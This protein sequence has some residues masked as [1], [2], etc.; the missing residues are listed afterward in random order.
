MG[1]KT[2][3]RLISSVLSL[4][5][6]C[7]QFVTMPVLAEENDVR[8]TTEAQLVLNSYEL[9]D[10]EKAILGNEGIVS[11][12]VKYEAPTGP[13]DYV[14]LD[15]NEVLS[16]GNYTDSQGNV[17]KP[18]L[19]ELVEGGNRTP[20]AL[21]DGKV[22]IDTDS[23]SYSVEVKY[24][25]YVSVPTETQAKLL[26]ATYI[27]ANASKA[28]ETLSVDAPAE[29]TRFDVAAQ[30]K[31][32]T[33]WL[34]TM[35]DG[36]EIQPAG[37]PSPMTVYI[38]DTDTIAAIEAMHAQ[39][40]RTGSYVNGNYDLNVLAQGYS[41]SDKI[42]YLLAS[43]ASV[44]TEA[45]ETRDQ[46]LSIY[47]NQQMNSWFTFAGDGIEKD[48]IGMILNTAFDNA[49]VLMSVVG[50]SDADASAGN[51]AEYA[52]VV[53][54]IDVVLGSGLVADGA[55]TAELTALI[56]AAVEAGKVT[57]RTNTAVQETL[58]VDSA[59]VV[60]SLNNNDVT[61][62]V[63]AEVY[64][65]SEKTT[66]TTNDVV[67]RLPTGTTYADVESAVK[68]DVENPFVSVND[69]AYQL[70]S[71]NYDRV[72]ENSIGNTLEEDSY[73]TIKYTPKSVQVTTA[74]DGINAEY[75]YGYGLMLPS[76]FEQNKAYTYT[77]VTANETKTLSEGSVYRITEA[78]TITRTEDK[79]SK[80]YRIL[81][82]LADD[83]NYSFTEAE[84]NVL[85]N[86]AVKS[87]VVSYK[88]PEA[89]DA[90][91]LLELKASDGTLTALP[92]ASG[93]AGLEWVPVG[94]YLNGVGNRIDFTGTATDIPEGTKSVKVDY[95]L[96][97]VGFDVESLLP[98][99]SKLINDSIAQK[100][101]LDSLVVE[102]GK[103]E[104]QKI[105]GATIFTALGALET[106][107]YSTYELGEDTPWENV[108]QK[109][110]EVIEIIGN[111][112]SDALE[113]KDGTRKLTVEGY[114]LNYKQNGL[115][116][117]YQKD[118]YGKSGYDYFMEQLDLLSVSL[119]A[120]ISS[121]KVSAFLSQPQYADYATKLTMVSESLGA[122]Q[123]AL[124]PPS[125]DVDMES[126][127]LASLFAL[128]EN[129]GETSVQT[130]NGITVRT[131]LLAAD[132]GV[133]T[134]KVTVTVN[135]LNLNDGEVKETVSESKKYVVGG[136]FTSEEVNEIA[137]LQATAE[138]QLA[139]NLDYYK[140]SITGKFP[141]T[142]DAVADTEIV[143]TYEPLI[144]SVNVNG[145]HV[146]N[147]S[148][149]DL[150]IPLPNHASAGW[151]YIYSID[152]TELVVTD[153]VYT[154]NLETFKSYATTGVLDITRTEQNVGETNLKEM[155]EIL[156]DGLGN[157]A[158][159]YILV[160]NEGTSSYS[161]R[162]SSTEYAVVLRLDVNNLA[163]LGTHLQD[164]VMALATKCDYTYQAFGDNVYW[165]SPKVSVQAIVDT[166]LESDLSMDK[167]NGILAEDGS[168]I[169]DVANELIGYNK[170]IVGA[171]SDLNNLGASLIETTLNIGLA[172][173]E[174]SIPFYL[175]IE[176]FGSTSSS[177]ATAK[178]AIAK[179]SSYLDI[180][181]END[182]LNV[183]ATAPDRLYQIALVGMLM[184]GYADLDDVTDVELEA[185]ITYVREQM[186]TVAVESDATTYQN[187]LDKLNAG[188]DLSEYAD[189]INSL[190]DLMQKVRGNVTITSESFV[191][192]TYSATF[193]ANIEN[194]LV[195]M[196][197]GDFTSFLAEKNI[198]L[199]TSLT[200]TN[201]GT[202]YEAVYFD[203]SKAGL[204][205]VYFT[206][207]FAAVAPNLGNN[208]IVIL[209]GDVAGDVVLNN[210]IILDLNGKT[211][212]SLKSNA[213][214][215][216]IFN[217]AF[218]TDGG[219]TGSIT[220]NFTIAGGKYGSDVSSMVVEGYTQTNGVVE[221]D[222]Y[223]AYMDGNKLVVE[224]EVDFLD[225]ARE[226]D[227]K[228]F[229][230]DLALQMGLEFY[231]ASK[232]NV[233]G[234]DIY[235]FESTDLIK[236]FFGDTNIVNK[237]LHILNYPGLT[238]FTNTVIDDLTNWG[239][240]AAA[241]ESGN[242]LVSYDLTTTPWGV[243]L[244]HV[245]AEDYLSVAVKG[246][247]S[248]AKDYTLE[249]RVRG[250][251]SDD[252]NVYLAKLLREFEKV[253]TVDADVVLN[254]VSYSNEHGLT[255]DYFGDGEIV[256]DFTQADNGTDYTTLM[257]LILAYANP[258]MKT[259]LQN[260]ID[261]GDVSGLI[262]AFDELTVANVI[263]AI[264]S[265]RGVSFAKLSAGYNASDVAYL[266]SIYH[267][268]LQGTAGV[269]NKLEVTGRS[270]KLGALAVADG[271]YEIEKSLGN[272]SG[273]ITLK[274]FAEKDPE[275]VAYVN[276]NNDLIKGYEIDYVTKE[277]RLDLAVTE[278]FNGLSLSKFYD[279]FHLGFTVNSGEIT[280]TVFD[281]DTVAAGMLRNGTV[282]TVE[283]AKAAGATSTSEDWKIL[284]LGDVNG[285]G[286]IDSNDANLMMKSYFGTVTLNDYQ[287]WAADVDGTG[288]VVAHDAL[289]NAMKWTL[290]D[291]YSS[292]LLGVA[293]E[294]R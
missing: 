184:T 72:V 89:E 192:N 283:F 88:T 230:I 209:L 206:K 227:L 207:D 26:N 98:I 127:A 264:K 46:V 22:T 52:N 24:D 240:L 128:L 66:I 274:L 57:D 241:V 174:M 71:G 182:T 282:I 271:V 80:P 159:K 199:P 237:A 105:D 292:K 172:G 165:N 139:S 56:D 116:M 228:Y 125:S 212:P 272:V 189:T 200:I 133:E 10:E 28:I 225:P 11:K 44:V 223:R 103:L 1:S 247:S 76:G 37:W 167:L 3:K 171:N 150:N 14:T 21:T 278:T 251:A 196:G 276:P 38:S 253:L 8:S 176:D 79:A 269:L 121:E 75:P 54:W 273:K 49:E 100:T 35:V 204:D 41:S 61:V 193:D 153:E 114:A 58:Y 67:L 229:A 268:F 123:A 81:N 155:F 280:N 68:N 137:G 163:S 205:K 6:L 249:I 157:G 110:Q 120:V 9:S 186:N 170:V 266:E 179:T 138:S 235:A 124:T 60:L 219:V 51:Y 277:I 112:K 111:I 287:L 254:D 220:G 183:I 27:L 289:Q 201:L 233:E 104:T 50:R 231:T 40:T 188:V 30:G 177:M 33:Q 119:P 288:A 203:N 15:E 181:T 215:T 141:T 245:A 96:A 263:S 117:Y 85:K 255:A 20:L 25:L 84:K 281:D 42:G 91:A 86:L 187:T 238:T 149:Y 92:Y 246:D 118:K 136:N 126:D 190:L 180:T 31:T 55:D 211:M 2:L 65:G 270:T 234:S 97:L 94:Y 214:T 107:I 226:T 45:K 90:D 74:I 178:K 131:S 194:L 224:L 115:S 244:T 243:A 5:I 18:V 59:T 290:K 63:D 261:K 262:D 16:V 242:P 101:A 257:G 48:A 82:L 191:N 34:M 175:S 87:E 53:N 284:I 146:K 70:S 32:M 13:G 39:A 23:Q 99:A 69:E 7:T 134:A 113:F 95:E 275:L 108:D 161:L 248:V 135:V 36:I 148:G 62:R 132:E 160:S 198:K 144:V 43:G 129:G 252:D 239:A 47:T 156:N 17:W 202:S 140:V 166:I 151:K 130:A 222:L 221:S 64:N 294:V 286:K 4:S 106:Y 195:N 109:D 216:K 93:Y 12:I 217:S 185:I 168:I 258:S 147:I 173:P 145:E 291:G 142:D 102:L 236:D 83:T 73:Y 77:L 232:L 279:V 256:I 210:G 164:F 293:K 197:Y 29:M 250:N 218:E 259:P 152:G 265:I 122:V 213:G 154:L 260:Y 78:V 267:V 208:A 285:N 158:S 169:D 162:R 143:I 19:V